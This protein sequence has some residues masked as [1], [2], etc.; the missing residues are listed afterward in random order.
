ME[1]RGFKPVGEF[2]PQNRCRKLAARESGA[3]LA[4][5]L[6]IS[7]QGAERRTEFSRRLDWRRAILES[8]ALGERKKVAYP[9]GVKSFISGP[10]EGWKDTP[11][12]RL[13]HLTLGIQ[14]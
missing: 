13:R 12:T 2:Y 6:E 10:N 5:E 7:E 4:G 14:S 11:W 3:W 9:A 8:C 1:A